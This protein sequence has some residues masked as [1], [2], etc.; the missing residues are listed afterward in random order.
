M[1]E[2]ISVALLSKG[3]L[4]QAS[5]YVQWDDPHGLAPI[6]ADKLRCLLTN[7]LSESE[8]DPMQLLGLVGRRIVGRLDLFAGQVVLD[9]QTSPVLFGSALFVPPEHRHTGMGLMLMLKMQSLWPATMV[10]GISQMVYPIYQKLR[11]TDFA[12]PRFV[13]VRHSYPVMRRYLGEGLHSR[14]LAP[15]ADV[16]LR[17]WQGGMRLRT[18]RP[19]VRDAE[20]ASLT[21]LDPAFASLPEPARC[22]R[23][24]AWVSWLLENETTGD[25]R[26]RSACHGLYDGSGRLVAYYVVK[27]R[28][29]ALATQ[30]NLRDLLLGSL[31]DWEVIDPSA[32]DEATIVQAAVRVL[33]EWG[34]DAIDVCT[35]DD[36]LQEVLR[37]SGFL[38]AGELRLLFKASPRSPLSQE[39]YRS[40]AAWRLRPCE[41][42]HFFT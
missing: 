10:C 33:T 5:P 17:A 2:A 8:D 32:V 42:D 13:L 12:L 4:R 6:K 26:S 20:L 7:P 35:D 1:T 14:L 34:A 30:R 40:R 15:V 41:G 31:S 25:P 24:A 28:F 22:H 36:A 9:G 18:R 19:V 16:C 27:L 29:H 11:W 21:D 23:S 38:A 39:R 37:G 3:Q